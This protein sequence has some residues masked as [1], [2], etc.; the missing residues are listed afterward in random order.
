MALVVPGLIFVFLK[1]AGRNEFDIPLYYEDGLPPLDGCPE[2]A[3]G[4]YRITKSGTAIGDSICVVVFDVPQDLLQR[5]KFDLKDE[6]GD[7]YALI[8][9]PR[10]IPDSAEYVL[11]KTC[12]IRMKEPWNTALIDAGGHIRGYYEIGNR[13]EMDRLRVELKILLK[14]Y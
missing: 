8:D 12:R 13:E 2:T 14:R 11:W 3:A 7:G 4:P 6:L 1:F 9:M 10:L 5:R